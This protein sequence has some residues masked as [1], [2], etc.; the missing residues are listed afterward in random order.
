[1]GIKFRKGILSILLLC[2]V[3]GIKAQKLTLSDLNKLVSWMSG[4]FSS[5]KQ[6]LSDTANY[7]DIHLKMIRIWEKDKDGYWLYVEQSIASKEDKPYRQRVYHVFLL[8]DSTIESKIYLLKNPLQY[9]T[10][11]SN[12]VSLSNI[13]TDSLVYKAGCDV[14]LH[15]KGDKFV[16]GTAGN[17]CESLLRGASYATTEVTIETDMLISW[18]RGFDKADKQAWGATMGGYHFDKLESYR[19]NRY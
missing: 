7:Y 15:K 10:K 8:N 11:L 2:T 4:S 18:D 16:G 19:L 6:H 9:A 14:Y 5:S 13:T 17:G 1:M 3:S 12:A